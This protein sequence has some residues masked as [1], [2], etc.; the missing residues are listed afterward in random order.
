MHGRESE[1]NLDS[2]SL[3]SDSKAGGTIASLALGRITSI[4]IM[5]SID[6]Q[7]KSRQRISHEMAN[8][9]VQSFRLAPRLLIIR[10]RVFE[11]L[12]RSVRGK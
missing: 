3:A 4:G 2:R 5:V 8:R 12:K 9:L 7:A 11:A 10:Y 1:S 6:R